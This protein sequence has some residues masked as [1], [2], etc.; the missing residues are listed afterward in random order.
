MMRKPAVPLLLALALGLGCSE[1]TPLEPSQLGGPRLNTNAG[2]THFSEQVVFSGVAFLNST[3]PNGVPAGFWIWC[4]ADSQNPYAGECNGSMYFYQLGI[5]RHV[6]GEITEPS[7]GFYQMKVS[8]TRDQAIVNCVLTNQAL[9]VRGPKNPVL[10]S[11]NTPG[12]HAT[13]PNAVVN[14]T[15]PPGA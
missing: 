7:D 4:E 8:S 1:P 15:G 14:V 12:G 6:E 11:C 3:F 2:S 13:S 5:T 10:V 9:A